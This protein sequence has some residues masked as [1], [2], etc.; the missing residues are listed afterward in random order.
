MHAT[1]RSLVAL[2]AIAVAFGLASPAS[3]APASSPESA[4]TRTCRHDLFLRSGIGPVRVERV[5]CRRA[6]R[7]LRSWVRRGMPKPGPRGW[8]CRMRRVGEEA[9]YVRARCSRRSARMRF[10][11]GG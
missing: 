7:T 6:I 3:A 11:I 8:R 5:S 4:A 2:G 1:L 10:E 9:P